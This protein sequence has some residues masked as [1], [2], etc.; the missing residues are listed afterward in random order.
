MNKTY[1]ARMAHR[2]MRSTVGIR[3]M[4]EWFQMSPEETLK[5]VFR[6]S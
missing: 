3:R 2:R 6:I 1:A 4:G 5:V